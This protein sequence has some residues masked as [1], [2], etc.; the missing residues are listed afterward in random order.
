[1]ITI[2][3]RSNAL[4]LTSPGR[5]RGELQL[6]DTKGVNCLHAVRIC[7]VRLPGSSR[8]TGDELRPGLFANAA[9]LGPN[10]WQQQRPIA[11]QPSD[12]NE[13]TSHYQQPRKQAE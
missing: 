5:L 13:V 2:Y 1:M 8:V 9:W 6:V 11:P 10:L 4:S 3:L 12:W 7:Q